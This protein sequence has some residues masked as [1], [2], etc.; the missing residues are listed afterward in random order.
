MNDGEQVSGA[1]RHPGRLKGRGVKNRS[2]RIFSARYFTGRINSTNG[3]LQK[4]TLAA[5][6]GRYSTRI[7]STSSEK[8][9]RETIAVFNWVIY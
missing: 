3:I 1:G 4:A 8:P 7:N 5:K 9:E 2:E 6:L